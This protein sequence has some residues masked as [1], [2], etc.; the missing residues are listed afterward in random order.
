MINTSYATKC[1]QKSETDASPTARAV[2]QH[3]LDGNSGTGGDDGDYVEE[4]LT[5]DEID[6]PA[7]D[8]YDI[9]TT[10]FK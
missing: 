4:E 3:E 9:N 2:Y 7:D 1:L 10:N 8:F 6:T 5:P